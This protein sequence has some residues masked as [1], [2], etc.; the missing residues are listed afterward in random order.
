MIT[1]L[2]FILTVM[3]LSF[4]STP[5]LSAESSFQDFALRDGDTVMF[6][7]DSITAAGIYGK[8]IENY[9]LLR[10]PHR[11]VR[12][13]NAGWGG[14]TA[15]GGLKRLTRDVLNRGATVVTV[16]YGVNDIGWGTKA[17]AEH[18]QIY[19]DGIRGIVEECRKRG[20]RVYI[21]SAAITGAD[22]ARSENDFLQRMCDDGMAL[23]K[24]LGGNAID[25]QRY[26]RGIQRKVWQANEGTTD[27]KAKATLHTEDGI[28]LNEM[29]QYA[30]ALAILK[31]LGAPS[32]VSS[33][34]LDFTNSEKPNSQGCRVS[35]VRATTDSLEFDRLDDGLPLNLGLG[36]LISYRFLP[37]ADELNRYMLTI[38]NLP[39]G[40]YDVIADGRLVG[41]YG[42]EALGAGQNLGSATPDPWIP[43]GP[44]DSQASVVRALTDS[45]FELA[46]ALRNGNT[47]L[48][49]EKSRKQLALDWERLNTEMESAQRRAARPTS[50][51]FV[52]RPAAK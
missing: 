50:Y 49:N 3:I 21:C 43:G 12:F 14:D 47:Y 31:G 8:V 24:S 5:V 4:R 25:V 29:G 42:H 51:H 41:T 36:W 11:K 40:R 33:A 44:W 13:L 16:A 27:A 22:P 34:T 18:R 30:M 2:L 19:L 20:V 10:Y 39:S 46:S 6:L 45:R 7:G 48:G 35:S 38:R 28:H 15:A 37:V 32:D 17:D 1:R 9:T 26:M 52:I 23:S